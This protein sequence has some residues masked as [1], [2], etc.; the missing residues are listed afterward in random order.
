MSAQSEFPG[1]AALA[2]LAPLFGRKPIAYPSGVAFLMQPY[3]YSIEK[4][5]RDLGYEP[6]VGLDEGLRRLKAS[7]H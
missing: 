1:F 5:R 6:S 7:L 4:A 3:A 2:A